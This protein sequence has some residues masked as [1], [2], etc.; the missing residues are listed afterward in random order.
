MPD[1]KVDK[2][3]VSFEATLGDE[4]RQAAQRL[5]SAS[6][7]GW[8]RPRPSGS[9]PTRCVSFSTPGKPSMAALTP[10]ELAQ[11]EAELGLRTGEPAA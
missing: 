2:M 8:H 4:I 7:P 5:A 10:D 3:S 9:A 11:A 6:R 1:M